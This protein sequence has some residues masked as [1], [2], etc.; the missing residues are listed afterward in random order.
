MSY[1]YVLDEE[2]NAIAVDEQ[3]LEEYFRCNGDP[4]KHIAFNYVGNVLISTLFLSINCQWNPEKPPLVFET[5]VFGGELDKYQIRYSTYEKAIEGHQA[6]AK[7]VL[8]Q[9]LIPA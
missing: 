7:L 3:Q 1:V 4:V 9:S 6:V 5:M 8:S 2:L